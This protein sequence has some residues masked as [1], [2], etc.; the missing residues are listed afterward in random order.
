MNTKQQG[1]VGVAMAVAYYTREGYVVSFPLTDNARYDLV[2]EKGGTFFRVQCKTTKYKEKNQYKVH[3]RTN[4]G[5]KT[6]STTKWLSSKEID[7][8]FVYAFDGTWWEFPPQEFDGKAS[9]SLGPSK[10]Q[11]K[12]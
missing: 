12:V 4:G 11:Y 5:N 8:L 10:Q 1:D 3:L 6:G 9:L 7:K 2:A